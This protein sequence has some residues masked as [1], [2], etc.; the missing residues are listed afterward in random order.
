[1]S[2]GVALCLVVLLV[3]A[4]GEDG[5][6]LT[7]FSAH[8]VRLRT[9]VIRYLHEPVVLLAPLWEKSMETDSIIPDTRSYEDVDVLRVRLHIRHSLDR[10]STRSNHRYPI[11]RPS[12]LLIVLGPA[13][14][15][16]DL[17][18]ELVLQARDIRP[19][20]VVQ[21]AGTMQQQIAM[22]LELSRLLPGSVLAQLDLPLA[23]LL[24]PVAANDL[25]VE[26]HVLPQI[27]C[28]DDLLEI[29]ED[30]RRVREESW[31]V[32]VLWADQLGRRDMGRW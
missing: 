14:S 19:L 12:F 22:I 24:V 18:F 10:R 26:G 7:P 5:Q 30:I 21:D 17:A 28:G 31:P 27:E 13:S 1:M 32:G 4:Y 25:R 2:E 3:L 9:K 23:F 29:L 16:H 11:I 6:L 8:Q 20:E 15:V